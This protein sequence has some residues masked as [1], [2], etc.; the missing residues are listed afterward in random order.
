MSRVAY[1]LINEMMSRILPDPLER[2]LYQDHLIV[3]RFGDAWG[4]MPRIDPGVL[5]AEGTLFYSSCGTY[6]PLANDGRIG[7][8]DGVNGC[9]VPQPR[10]STPQHVGVRF[11]TPL[12]VTGFQFSCGVRELAACPYAAGP[13][14]YPSTFVLEASLDETSWV[15]LLSVTGYR[16]MR[17]ATG[18]PIPGDKLEEY[19]TGLIFISDRMDVPNDAFYLAY[20]MRIEA[21]VPD[22]NGNYNVS[23]LIFYGHDA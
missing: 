3:H 14:A 9:W 2:S 21:A 16:G 20:R 22:I 10:G 13:C 19:E 17:A 8:A 7:N 11:E 4:Y 18:S 23:E 5:M 12:M 15:P 6:W 1:H